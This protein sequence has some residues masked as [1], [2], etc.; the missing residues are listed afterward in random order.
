MVVVVL[1]RRFQQLDAAATQHGQKN[2]KKPVAE[3]DACN[4]MLL[5]RAWLDTARAAERSLDVLDGRVGD[6]AGAVPR[7]AAGD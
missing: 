4:G 1:D 2:Q 5:C 3:L 7:Q 6:G